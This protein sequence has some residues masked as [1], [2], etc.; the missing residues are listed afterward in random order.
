[1][2][3]RFQPERHARAL[4]RAPTRSRRC[5]RR[6]RSAACNP[7]IFPR[8]LPGTDIS[9]IFDTRQTAQLAAYGMT[10]E[11][12]PIL[13]GASPCSRDG[14]VPTQDFAPRFFLIAEG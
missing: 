13:A 12:L 1:M 2:A 3:A 14:R 11:A 4:L 10:N 5:A 6:T 8:L 9:S 7:T